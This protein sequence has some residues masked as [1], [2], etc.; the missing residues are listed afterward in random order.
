MPPFR[1]AADPELERARQ[2]QRKPELPSAKWSGRVQETFTAYDDFGWDKIEEYL[3]TK[4]PN[5]DF[6]PRVFNGNWLFE[7]PE[8]LTEG[9]KRE[10]RKRRDVS[11]RTRSPSVSPEPEERKFQQE[12][13]RV[14]SA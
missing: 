8:R 3:K 10:L 6:K 11:G 7:V 4:W 5:W 9:E 14:S 1:R 12:Q 2:A 13:G